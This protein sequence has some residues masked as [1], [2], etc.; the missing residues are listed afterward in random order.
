MTSQPSIKSFRERPRA[1]A[2]LIC[3]K[4][5]ES[6]EGH[7]LGRASFDLLSKP[8]ETL[9]VWSVVQGRL[10]FGDVAEASVTQFD[11]KFVVWRAKQT[12]RHLE[13]STG[14]V[15]RFSADA[16]AELPRGMYHL[17]LRVNGRLAG[18]VV[19]R[20]DQVRQQA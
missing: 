12:I 6:D 11:S 7:T 14:S 13:R 9:L 17:Y 20:F 3:R 1:V 19:F 4:V 16:P 5:E 18:R 2:L 8:G 10:T 15:I